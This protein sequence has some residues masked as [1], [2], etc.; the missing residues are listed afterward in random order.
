MAIFVDI[1]FQ[2]G[3]ETKSDLAKKS[4]PYFSIKLGDQ[5]K[6]R[7]FHIACKTGVKTPRQWTKKERKNK[8]IMMWRELQKSSQ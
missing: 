4:L 5:G 2:L 7:A 3:S 6:A 1:I 8:T